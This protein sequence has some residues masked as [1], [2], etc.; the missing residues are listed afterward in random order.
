MKIIGFDIYLPKYWHQDLKEAQDP[1]NKCLDISAW[2]N[3]HASE[4][5]EFE[6]TIDK[7]YFSVFS[8]IGT[9]ILSGLI[10]NT[11]AQ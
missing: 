3:P 5:R 10:F 11:A 4:Y 1:C 8:N 7:V 6:V 2:E 9:G